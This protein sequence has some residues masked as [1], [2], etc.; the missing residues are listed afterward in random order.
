[1]CRCT[2]NIRTPWCGKHDCETP[3]QK[4][5]HTYNRVSLENPWMRLAYNIA[6]GF[7]WVR[8][9]N[10]KTTP[11]AV[12][13]SP[14]GQYLGHGACADGMHAIKGT[15]NR[16]EEKG[17]SYDTCPY[18]H[19]DEHAEKRALKAALSKQPY[20]I[21]SSIYIYGH[22]K[23]CDHCIQELH[24]NGIYHIYILENA[25]VLF[26]RHHKDT[27]LGTPKQFIM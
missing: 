13:V 9:W 12:I 16:L 15:C 8:G 23:V 17:T 2:P 27:V 20:L 19:E 26:D 1:M 24:R 21:G 3:P 25:E 5:A 10:L 11:V 14:S 7:Y 22:Y 18:C 4:G 6:K